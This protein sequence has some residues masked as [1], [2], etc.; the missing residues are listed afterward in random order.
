MKQIWKGKLKH[1]VICPTCFT[2]HSRYSEYL[3]PLDVVDE[4]LISDDKGKA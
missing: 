1:R 2:K 3:L 4:I